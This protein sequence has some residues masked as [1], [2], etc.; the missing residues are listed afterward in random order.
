MSK[1]EDDVDSDSI[2]PPCRE[3][4]VHLSCVYTGKKAKK[5]LKFMRFLMSEKHILPSSDHDPTLPNRA[6]FLKM[7]ITELFLKYG[8]EFT[9]NRK[10]KLAEKRNQP[11]GN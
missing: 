10:Q 2:L 1:I 4:E 8:A 5:V 9:E 6:Q 7:G 11:D 3:Q